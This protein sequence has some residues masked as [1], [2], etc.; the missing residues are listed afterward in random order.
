[1]TKWRYFSVA[2][3]SQLPALGITQQV[4]S[5]G[6]PDF[7]QTCLNQTNLQPPRRLSHLSSLLLIVDRYS[8]KYLSVYI[9]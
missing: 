8:T 2:L 9:E 6:S 4:W 3:S 1:M 5:L 7:P